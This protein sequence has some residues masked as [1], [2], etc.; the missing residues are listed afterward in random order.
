MALGSHSLRP[1]DGRLSERGP[2]TSHALPSVC[3][4]E[5]IAK[6]LR[7]ESSAL[8]A[9][10]L[11]SLQDYASRM[12]AGTRNIYYLCAPNR[13]LAEHSPYYEAMKQKNTE[14]GEP[15][16]SLRP[17]QASLHMSFPWGQVRG[18]SEVWAPEGGSLCLVENGL[19][20]PG[21]QKAKQRESVS[22][23]TGVGA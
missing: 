18:Q 13:H 23:G 10:Q 21:P 6:L 19:T 2:G 5:D 7:Y 4:Q 20:C 3:L 17:N 1:A 16:G 8:P 15:R 12:Q 11:T 9:G 22:R 14:V